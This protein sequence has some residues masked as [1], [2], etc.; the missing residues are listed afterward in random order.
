M[1]GK[2]KN[3]NAI[4]LPPSIINDYIESLIGTKLESA[5]KIGIKQKRNVAIKEIKETVLSA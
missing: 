1:V 3:I 2:E 4:Q 5:L